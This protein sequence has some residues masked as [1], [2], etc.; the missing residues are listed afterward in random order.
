MIPEA[1]ILVVGHDHCDVAPLR[2][3]AQPF[4]QVGDMAISA[5]EIRV[6]GMLGQAP[7][8]LVEGNLR[9]RASVDIAEKIL[10]VLEMCGAICGTWCKPCV[11]VERLMVGLEVGALALVRIDDLALF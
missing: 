10:S 4:E 3:L 8:G 5:E 7:H 11:V 6:R 1:T 2:A 9:E